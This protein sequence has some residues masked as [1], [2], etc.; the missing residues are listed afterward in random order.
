MKLQEVATI[1]GVDVINYG[2]VTDARYEVK[3]V[4]NM[5]QA[6]VVYLRSSN[7]VKIVVRELMAQDANQH[8]AQRVCGFNPVFAK[9][10]NYPNPFA[11]KTVLGTCRR[12]A[13]ETAVEQV[14]DDYNATHSQV[15]TVVRQK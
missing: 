3:I 1:T 12:A 6:D 8:A 10:I 13:R 9:Y 7:D 4:N 5:G 14:I 2:E 15:L 11:F